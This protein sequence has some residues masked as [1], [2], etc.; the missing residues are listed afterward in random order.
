MRFKKTEVCQTCAKLK[1]VCQTCMLDLEYGLPVEVPCASI[2]LLNDRPV[3]HLNA[4]TMTGLATVKSA[5]N[6]VYLLFRS[7]ANV[8]HAVNGKQLKMPLFYTNRP[9]TF[10]LYVKVDGCVFLVPCKKCTQVQKRMMQDKS[11]FTN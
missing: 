2:D 4:L 11:F 5:L 6:L 1:N 10:G 8:R 7:E 9:Q 3:I